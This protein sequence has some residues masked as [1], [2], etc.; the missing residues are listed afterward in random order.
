MT[1][2]KFRITKNMANIARSP[3]IS[4]NSS[5]NGLDFFLGGCS[6]MGVRELF[7][8]AYPLAAG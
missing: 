4:K 2:K 5:K 6:L 3:K 8:K 1:P 7:E